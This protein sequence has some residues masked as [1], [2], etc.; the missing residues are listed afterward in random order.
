MRSEPSSEIPPKENQRTIRVRWSIVA[1]RNH[2]SSTSLF[3]VLFVN[4]PLISCSLIYLWLHNLEHM[5]GRE[6]NRIDNC[7]HFFIFLFSCVLNFLMFASQVYYPD[8]AIFILY[9]KLLRNNYICIS[10]SYYTNLLVIITKD[11]FSLNNI[12]YIYNNEWTDIYTERNTWEIHKRM[13]LFLTFKI[14]APGLRCTL[15]K[16]KRRKSDRFISQSGKHRFGPVA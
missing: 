7:I 12:L 9:I 11:L 13:F 1:G 4:Y 14:N 10:F 16:F 3:A 5:V 2:F 15:E 8:Y 6:W